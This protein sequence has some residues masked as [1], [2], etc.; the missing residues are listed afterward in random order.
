MAPQILVVT[1]L[2][3]TDT[4]TLLKISVVRLI[5]GGNFEGKTIRPLSPETLKWQGGPD[6]KWVKTIKMMMH[7]LFWVFRCL[8]RLARWL[9]LFWVTIIDVITWRDSIK[10]VQRHYLVTD[11]PGDISNVP[12]AF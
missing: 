10:D 6:R 11:L 9:V 8:H 1:P 2:T 4:R 12:E 3:L 7:L 5:C